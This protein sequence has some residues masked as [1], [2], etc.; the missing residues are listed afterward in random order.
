MNGIKSPEDRIEETERSVL[1]AYFSAVRS[2]YSNSSPQQRTSIRRG[3]DRLLY[4]EEKPISPVKL[5]FDKTKAKEIRL[6]VQISQK[7]L[8]EQLKISPQDIRSYEY[9]GV[10]RPYGEKNEKYLVWLKSKGYNP[11]NISD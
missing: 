9:R 11:F 5:I 1:E 3:L 4:G 8:A 6:S 7:D 10:K 2:K